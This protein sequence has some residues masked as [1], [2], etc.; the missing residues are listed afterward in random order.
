MMKISKWRRLLLRLDP[1]RFI[2]PFGKY[3]GEYL[4]DIEIDDPDYIDWLLSVVKDHC[5]LK[6]CLDGIVKRRGEGE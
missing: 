6:V 1:G 4:D 3:K 2:M 5:E